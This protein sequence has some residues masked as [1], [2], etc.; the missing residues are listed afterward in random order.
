MGFYPDDAHEYKW[1]NKLHLVRSDGPKKRTFGSISYLV[2][3][4]SSDEYNW[5]SPRDSIRISGMNFSEEQV[6]EH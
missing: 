6:N 3:M 2:R 5:S 1:V 4:R